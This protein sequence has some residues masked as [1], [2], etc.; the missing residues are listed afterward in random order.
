MRLY[1]GKT[2]M[3]RTPA[4]RKNIN[5]PDTIL[6][7]HERLSCTELQQGG[8]TSTSQIPFSMLM[9]TLLFPRRPS[10]MT[11]TLDLRSTT[12]SS[13]PTLEDFQSQRGL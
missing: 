6:Y 12:L 5:I 2:L 3:Y 9:M 8:R 10:K 1:E 7:A 11:S 13:C 4:R